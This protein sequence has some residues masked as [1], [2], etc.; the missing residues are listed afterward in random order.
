[1]DWSRF[2]DSEVSYFLFTKLKKDRVVKMP[3]PET[4][5]AKALREIEKIARD[6][7]STLASDSSMAFEQISEAE[8]R[9]VYNRSIDSNLAL[10]NSFKHPIKRDKSG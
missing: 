8:H 6:H 2:K 1:M 3:N 10:T 5:E 7:F 4:N 9:N